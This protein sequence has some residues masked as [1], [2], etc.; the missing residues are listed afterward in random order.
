ML[1]CIHHVAQTV[2]ILGLRPSTAKLRRCRVVPVEAERGL[3]CLTLVVQR[4][5]VLVSQIELH[6]VNGAAVHGGGYTVVE[7][8]TP[9]LNVTR[10]HRDGNVGQQTA[11]ARTAVVVARVGER[12]AVELQTARAQQS[13]GIAG[14]PRQ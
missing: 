5:R 7:P 14:S 9:R 3:E 12:R 11:L 4:F 13:A 2:R 6:R 8:R 1:P 10:W